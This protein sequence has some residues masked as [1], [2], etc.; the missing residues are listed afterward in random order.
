MN[1]FRSDLHGI[2]GDRIKMHDDS[3]SVATVSSSNFLRPNQ[4]KTH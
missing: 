4:N 1:V 3:D 2:D